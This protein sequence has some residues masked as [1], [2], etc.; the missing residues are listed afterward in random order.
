MNRL[1]FFATLLAPAIALF[2]P[3]KV[4]AKPRRWTC[5]KLITNSDHFSNE[6]VTEARNQAR[7]MFLRDPL[8]N[9]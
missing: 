4:F 8:L 6:L 7:E 2:S 3:R 5:F 1:A 9:K